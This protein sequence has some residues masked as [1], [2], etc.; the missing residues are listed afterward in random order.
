MSESQTANAQGGRQASL[1]ELRSS[2]VPGETELGVPESEVAAAGVGQQRIRAHTQSLRE[3]VA[4]TRGV[5]ALFYVTS[6]LIHTQFAYAT[7]NHD[8]NSCSNNEQPNSQRK[9]SSGFTR[10]RRVKVS[11]CIQA[12]LLT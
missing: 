5:D 11:S 8:L 4:S 12:R 7:V 6:S 2:P 9:F 1:W 10:D 3:Q